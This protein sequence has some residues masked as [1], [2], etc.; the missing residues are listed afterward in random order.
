MSQTLVNKVPRLVA[1]TPWVGQACNVWMYRQFLGLESQLKSIITWEYV[2]REQF[3]L[4]NTDIRF[5]PERFSKPLHGLPRIIDGLVEPRVGGSRFGQAFKK[6]LRD[7]LVQTQAEAVLAQFGH[8]AMDIEG[9]ARGLSVPVFAHF[10]GHDMS[11]RLRK[12]R[13]RQ[14]LQSHWHPFAGMIVVAKY[15]RDYLLDIGMESDSVALIPCGAP[16]RE[17]VA[18]VDEIK[19]SSPRVDTEF[20]FLFVGRFTAKKDPISVLRC[21]QACHEVYPHA[22]LRMGGFGEL[23]T[24]CREWISAQPTPFQDAVDLLGSLS[25]TQVLFEMARSDAFVQHSRVAPSGDM[26]G[27]PVSIG[28]AMA[29]GLPIIATRHAGIVDQVVEGVSGYLCDEGDWVQMGHDMIQLM[30][31]RNRVA[32][33]GNAAREAAL[34]VDAAIQIKLLRDFINQRT[35]HYNAG[36]R[37]QAA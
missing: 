36:A 31:D 9:A 12:K 23:E 10:H 35:A 1:F 19:A 3:P 7:Q 25:P 37:R 27:W 28:E 6:W 32:A 13:Y 5:V 16:S 18:T 20:R 15:Q 29:A 33:M 24:E 30:S 34:N 2:N 8:Y 4:A 17:I 14:A 21:F 11:A 22:R 26:E